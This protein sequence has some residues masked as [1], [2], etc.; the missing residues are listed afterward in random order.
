MNLRAI[1][2]AAAILAST[3]AFAA[4]MP[5]PATSGARGL[6]QQIG[7]N[8]NDEDKQG[9][10]MQTCDD[11]WIKASQAYSGNVEDAKTAKKAC[12]AKCGCEGAK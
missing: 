5:A 4:P 8:P 1:M 9:H 3:A 10:C 7:C 6:V 12:N 11:D 2:I